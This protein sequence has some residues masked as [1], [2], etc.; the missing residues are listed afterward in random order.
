MSSFAPPVFDNG[1]AGLPDT[2][3]SRVQPTPVPDPYLVCHSPSALALLGLPADA[4]THPDLLHT[5]AG[6]RT[7]PGMDPMAALYAGH[8]FGHFVPQL[9]DGR[10]ILLGEMQGPDGQGWEIQLKGAGRTPYSRGGDGRAVLRSSI[11][12]FLCSEAM[13]ALGIPTT[14]SMAVVETGEPV[15]RETV[16]SGAVLTRIAASH[17]RVGTFEYA[18]AREDFVGLKALADYSINRHYPEVWQAE[19]PYFAFLQAVI[20]RQAH[21]IASWMHV[22]FVHA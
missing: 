17:I 15:L 7:L 18:A 9:G 13:H 10:A 20:K 1:F 2:F 5:L 21:L 4:L 11:R 14:R 19:N 16:L 8:Q 6:N 12:E 3:Y 22:G